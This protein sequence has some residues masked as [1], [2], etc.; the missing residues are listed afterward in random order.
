MSISIEAELVGLA[1]EAT[2]ANDGPDLGGSMSAALSGQVIAA[3]REACRRAV[4]AAGPRLVEA[5]YLCQVATTADALGRVYG[6]LHRRRAQVLH[7]QLREGSGL[8]TVEVHLPVADSFGLAAELRHKS[9][10]AASAQLML[11]HWR[12]LGQAAADDG[13][14]EAPCTSSSA[15]GP[16][17]GRE[18]GGGGGHEAGPLGLEEGGKALT[19]RLVEAVRRRKG[20]PVE[21][22]LV[23]E[24]TKQRTLARKV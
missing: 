19:R 22:H 11:S 13:A 17:N 14:D 8:F 24:A 6:V 18:G 1:D 20:L 2:G 5:L 16:G 21:Q 3:A 4:A 15:A 10:G 9:S 23:K 12:R 7:E